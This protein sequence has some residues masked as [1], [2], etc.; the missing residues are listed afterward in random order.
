MFPWLKDS[1]LKL[2]K[3][4]NGT[5]APNSILIYGKDGLGKKEIAHE[6]ASFYL[7]FNKNSAGYCGSCPSCLNMAGG[8]HGDFL[9]ISSDNGSQIGIEE[10]RDMIETMSMSRTADTACRQCSA[11]NPG[12][13]GRRSAF[14]PDG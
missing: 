1:W 3:V 14:Y 8:T 6:L 11:E 4:Y 7:C 10:I 9:T 5:H 12:G 13:A 2:L